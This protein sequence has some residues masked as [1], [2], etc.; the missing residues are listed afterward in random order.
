MRGGEKGAAGRARAR[1]HS[2]SIRASK[3][4]HVALNLGSLPHCMYILYCSCT[5]PTLVRRRA[6]GQCCTARGVLQQ[7]VPPSP[8][9][10]PSPCPAHL[11]SGA[12]R[13]DRGALGRPTLRW[14]HWQQ[15]GRCRRL[16]LAAAVVASR[17]QAAYVLFWARAGCRRAAYA[18]GLMNLLTHRY[19]RK[20]LTHRYKRKAAHMSRPAG[21]GWSF[22]VEGAGGPGRCHWLASGATARLL[23]RQGMPTMRRKSR[24]HT[25]A[26]PDLDGWAPPPPFEA[27]RQR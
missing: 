1:R 2:C 10:L 26:Q 20:A 4:P 15:G 17:R 11:R 5:A 18:L 13:V 7:A 19:K 24:V 12:W 14:T 16:D 23:R 9:P 27:T 8:P 25:A 22:R 3:A 6:L 21:R